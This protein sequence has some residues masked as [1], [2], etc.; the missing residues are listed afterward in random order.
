MCSDAG[1]LQQGIALC[2]INISWIIKHQKCKPRSRVVLN[3][4]TG[5]R[6]VFRIVVTL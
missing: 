4:P 2:G 1:Q 6:N 5:I 3:V